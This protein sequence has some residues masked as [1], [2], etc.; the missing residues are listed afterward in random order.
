MDRGRTT[1]KMT[2]EE[3]LLEVGL[4]STIASLMMQCS[5]QIF[6]LA[7]AKLNSFVAGRAFETN[8]SGRFA[9]HII[10]SVTKVNAAKVLR[11]FLPQLFRYLDEALSTEEVLGEETLP[12]EMLFNLHLLS[13]LVKFF[14]INFPMEL[15]TFFLT[16][17]EMP[18]PFSPTLCRANYPH[19]GQSSTIEIARRISVCRRGAL[20][21]P[22]EPHYNLSDRL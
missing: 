11:T 14:K 19:S 2:R 8:V 9:A 22:S 3:S 10:A 5:D 17:D 16:T 21:L 7:L 6:D 18:W 1:E 12:D 20:Q 15:S 13:E 4:S